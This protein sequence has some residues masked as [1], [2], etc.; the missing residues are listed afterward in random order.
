VKTELSPEARAVI[1]RLEERIER[2]EKGRP[3]NIE[4]V[5]LVCFSGEWDRL[6][7]A[8]TIANGALAMGQEVHMFF[9]F[10][11]A[12]AIRDVRRGGPA[13]TFMDKLIRK[14]LPGGVERAPLSKLNWGGLGKIFIKRRMRQANV[15]S[16]EDLMKRAEEMGARFHLCETSA[17]ILGLGDSQLLVGDGVDRCGVA[18]FLSEASGR[19][20][21][22][23]I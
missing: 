6:F 14:M 5:N 20:L 3:E 18:T 10:W 9:T 15:E 23:F 19:S 2:L 11:A 7:A 8:F 1:T 16:I 21:V 12:A 13:N 22:L 4:K 17:S